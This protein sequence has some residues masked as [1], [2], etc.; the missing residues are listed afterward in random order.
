MFTSIPLNKTI[1][2][3]VK[4]TFDNNPNI[5]ITKKDLKKLFEFATSG[6]H[7]LFG[8]NYYDEIAGVAM[9][10]PFEPVLAN[11][12]NGFYEK[13]WLKE[14]NFCKDLLCRCYGDNKICLFNF[15]VG[16]MKLLDYLNSGHLNIKYIFENQDDGKLAFLDVLISSENDNFCTSVFRKKINW[17]LH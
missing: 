8:E 2:L 7:F 14:F 1:D 3:T 12:F 9:G 16:A 6:T 5:K 4:L 15:E 17:P 11:L 10:S 13:Q